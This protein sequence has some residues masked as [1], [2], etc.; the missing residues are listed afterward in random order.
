MTQNYP[1]T[2]NGEQGA[3]ENTRGGQFFLPAVDIVETE[4]ELLLVADVPGVAPGDVDLRFENDE[5]IL[6]AKRSL[7]A[8][9]GKPLRGEYKEGDFYRLFR[10]H[11][12]IDS[13]GI[14]AECAGGVLT[15]HLPK[16][17]KVKPRKVLVKAAS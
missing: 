16:V 17:E 7:P 4:E 12:S 6:Q 2:Q 3:V 10:V 9:A 1:V 5:L 8:R 14:A 11:E 15:V 13:T